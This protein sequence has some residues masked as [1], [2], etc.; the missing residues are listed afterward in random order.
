MKNCN[1]E[2]YN[3]VKILEV[4]ST[5]VNL[6]LFGHLKKGIFLHISMDLAFFILPNGFISYVAAWN[7]SNN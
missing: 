6:E 5:I 2:H 1:I 7:G 4:N 3:S